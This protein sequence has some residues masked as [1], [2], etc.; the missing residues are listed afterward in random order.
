MKD[1]RM[2]VK[3]A[4]SGGFFGGVTALFTVNQLLRQKKLQKIKIYII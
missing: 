1:I 2:V 3:D 4:I